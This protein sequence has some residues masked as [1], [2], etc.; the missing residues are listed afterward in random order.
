MKKLK[1]FLL[2][3][4]GLIVM[5]IGLHFFLIASDLAAGG[6]IGLAMVINHFVPIIPIGIVMTVMNV[7]LILVALILF[8]KKFTAN[9]IYSSLALSGIIFLFEMF[10]PLSGPI[11][12]DTLLNLIFGIVIQGLGMGLI[13]YQDA[14][15]G[16]TDIVAKV[17]NKYF[18]TEIGR[19]LLITDFVVVISAGFAF[20]FTLGLWA[21][22]GIVLNGLVIDRVIAG[23]EQKLHVV[24]ISK[25]SKQINDFV[26]KSIDRTTTIY[27]AVGGYTGE[28]KQVIQAILNKKEY[29]KLKLFIRNLDPNAFISVSFTHEVLG[30]GFNQ[31]LNQ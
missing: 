12:D 20:G 13:F 5:A 6:I 11:V 27:E 22:V 15:T 25:Q 18:H 7:V 9:T 19:A 10:F 3:N 17:I 21:F 23:F 1:K 31:Y 8:G 4:V 26:V 29:I 14:S 28:T 2:I 16:G 24:V 30:E